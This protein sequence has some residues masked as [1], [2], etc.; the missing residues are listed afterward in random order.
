MV[1]RSEYDIEGTT[2]RY[3]DISDISIG[4]VRLLKSTAVDGPPLM[5]G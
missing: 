4:Y 5:H 3:A 1:F 2:I